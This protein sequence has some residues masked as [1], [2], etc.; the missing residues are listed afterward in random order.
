MCFL[1]P[2]A[3]P[4]GNLSLAMVFRKKARFFL[5]ITHGAIGIIVS[6]DFV[7]YGASTIEID[8]YPRLEYY[9]ALSW[10]L[11]HQVLSSRR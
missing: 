3:Y 1:T 2:K 5:S 9:V 10:C 11:F 6:L 4:I 8:R 7:A